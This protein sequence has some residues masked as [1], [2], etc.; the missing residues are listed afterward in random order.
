MA[1]IR[2]VEMSVG[3]AGVGLLISDLNIDFDITRTNTKQYNA[4]K[5][6]IY[7]AKLDTQQRILTQ[8]S[9]VIF[10][11]GYVDESNIGI[12]YS[13]TVIDGS[14]R[15][16]GVNR[17]TE[18]ICADINANRQALLYA[19]V[20]FSYKAKTPLSVVLSAIA[21]Q[22]GIPV[23]GLENVNI[24][25]NNGFVYSGNWTNLIRRL[26]K[27]L[28]AN[29]L[30]LYFDNNEMVIFTRG[31]KDDKFGSAYITPQTGLIGEV[32]EIENKNE[33]DTKKRIKFDYYI[34]PKL[35][36]NSVAILKSTKLSGVFIIDKIR[37]V[38]NNY[39][40][41]FRSTIEASTSFATITNV[42]VPA[43]MPSDFNLQG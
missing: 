43:K 22:I 41:N 33:Q 20:N 36:P 4:A 35:R 13:G 27:I 2:K 12:I 40:G 18:L 39:G 10:K 28:S 21:G 38:G 8:G 1:F 11:A 14:T 7:N 29:N 32:Q 25:L 31:A 16:A 37:F 26:D 24:V 6:K 3:V 23:S 19:T 42:E 9:N 17:V 34:N 5:F 30:Y 15:R